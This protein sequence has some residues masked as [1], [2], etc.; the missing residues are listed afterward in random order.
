MKTYRK[1]IA[2]ID[3]LI[4]FLISQRMRVALKIE[5]EKRKTNLPI[6]FPEVEEKKN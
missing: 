2:L 4:L 3:Y 6:S 1:I 5:G